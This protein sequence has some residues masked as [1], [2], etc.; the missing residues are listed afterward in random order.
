MTSPEHAKHRPPAAKFVEGLQVAKEMG[1]P[2]NNTCW[3]ETSMNKENDVTYDCTSSNCESRVLTFICRSC[4]VNAIQSAMQPHRCA[5]KGS[6][7]RDNPMIHLQFIDSFANAL[8][9]EYEL[10]ILHIYFNLQGFERR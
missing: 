6:Q 5:P 7:E 8:C 10:N 9:I 3:N 2:S 1:G 4:L